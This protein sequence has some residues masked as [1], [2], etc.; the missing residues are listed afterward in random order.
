[1]YYSL[2]MRIFLLVELPLN[3]FWVEELEEIWLEFE[4]RKRF[5]M[6]NWLLNAIISSVE[7]SILIMA[8]TISQL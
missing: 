3:L 2:A 5:K 6:L 4:T 8:T 7:I 1:M